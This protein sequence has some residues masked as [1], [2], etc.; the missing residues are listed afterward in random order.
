MKLSNTSIVKHL[1]SSPRK[2][3]TP[4]AP[5]SRRN[6][7]SKFSAVAN[8]SQCS[9]KRF[10]PIQPTDNNTSY[11][12]QTLPLNST[13]SSA[14]LPVSSSSN[15]IAYQRQF[16]RPLGSRSSSPES[17]PQAQPRTSFIK[18]PAYRYSSPPRPPRP[19]PPSPSPSSP[20]YVSR[21][22][23]RENNSIATDVTPTTTT[24]MT[25][26]G[27]RLPLTVD[28]GSQPSSSIPNPTLPSS[29]TLS[30]SN[31]S[32]SSSSIADPTSSSSSL[33]N[34]V[35]QFVPLSIYR[36]YKALFLTSYFKCELIY[37]YRTTIDSQ[38]NFLN[39]QLEAK[40]FFLRRKRLEM[41]ARRMTKSCNDLCQQQPIN[42]E[43]DFELML[44]SETIPTL[45][46]TKALIKRMNYLDLP[47]TLIREKLTP[48]ACN[49]LFLLYAIIR[50]QLGF[51]FFRF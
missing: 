23:V 10:K 47:Q 31:L 44:E 50:D 26:N 12:K 45:E 33:P 13:Y 48:M 22:N 37:S 2:L 6:L 5:R 24:T 8:T 15:D 21:R 43:E 46:N 39:I 11:T 19:Q 25:Q 3:K 51:S 41:I 35:I 18:P 9:S 14:F 29:S 30:T 4:Q 34:Q 40:A 42:I 7:M 20:S 36:Q 27:I 16:A 28:V 17:I 32:S 1:K 38:V 49:D